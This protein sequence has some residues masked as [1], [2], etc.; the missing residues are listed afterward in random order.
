MAARIGKDPIAEEVGQRIRALREAMGVNSEQF[1]A[2][3]GHG[4]GTQSKIERATVS[5]RLATLDKIARKLGIELLDLLLTPDLLPRHRLIEAT[6][7]M[8][9]A[10]IQSLLEL[11][12]R[13]RPAI[14]ATVPYKLV[15]RP[16]RKTDPPTCVELVPIEVA[17]G[18]FMSA[19]PRAD[20][21]WVVP[22]TRRKLTKDYFVCRVVG[23]S[24]ESLIPNGSHVL[25]SRPPRGDLRGKIILVQLKGVLDDD[26]GASYTVKRFQCDLDADGRQ[27]NVRLVPLNHAF[28]E[29]KIDPSRGHDYEPVA[30]LIEVLGSRPKR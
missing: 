5:P 23:R 22:H 30:E 4:N 20:S 17:A 27:T 16:R 2:S 9:P 13:L 12:E 14:P 28:S 15:P 11:A 6:V 25:F 18:G 10:D 7:G 1:A 19:S 8:P 29:I 24:M 26:T 3:V 21:A